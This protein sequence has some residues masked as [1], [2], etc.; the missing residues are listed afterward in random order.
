[1]G[2][3]HHHG[4]GLGDDDLAPVPP[5]VQRVLAGSV[6]VVV[7]LTIIGLAAWWPSGDAVLDT[8]A[9]GF[10]DRVDATV[11]SATIEPCSYDPSLDCDVV[12]AEIDGSDDERP[13]VAVLEFD[14]GSATPAATLRTG[15]GIVLNDAGPDVPDVARYSFAD[16]QRSRPLLL[17]GLVF[18]AAVVALGRWR[19]LL[20]VV[21]LAGSLMVLLLFALPALLR[22]S[23]PVGVALT[24]ASIIAIG[25]LYLAH[26]LN[27]RTTVALLGTLSSLLLVA[28]LAAVFSAAADLTGLASEESINLLAF[29]PELDFRGLLL[30]AAIIGALGVLDDVTVTQVAAVTELHRSDP[31]AGSRQLYAA[32]VRIGRDHIASTV[33]T[34][35]LAYA[36]AALPLLLIFTQSGLSTVDVLTSETVAVEIVQTLV[37]SIGLVAAVPITTALAVWVVPRRGSATYS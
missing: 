12:R 34:L 9:L 29:A 15:D 28:L 11:V 19:G 3:S 30:A 33:N 8:Q 18:V 4:H 31:A 37:G 14:L 35:V 17:L 23:S 21:G 25:A 7:L 20:A 32:G 26:G 1:M 5:V 13:E 6:A 36:A 16:F 10:A 22:G 24:T 27:E 2:A